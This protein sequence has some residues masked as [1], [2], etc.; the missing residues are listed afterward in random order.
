MSKTFKELLADVDAK[1]PEYREKYK[2]LAEAVQALL[3]AVDAGVLI[4]QPPA[5]TTKSAA[6]V[7]FI[8]FKVKCIRNNDRAENSLEIGKI[9]TVIGAPYPTDYLLD[10]GSPISWARDRFEIVVEEPTP[11]PKTKMVRAMETNS[12]FLTTGK[13]YEA[14][15]EEYGFDGKAYMYSLVDDTGTRNKFYITRFE[16]VLDSEGELK[17]QTVIAADLTKLT[18]DLTYN[19]DAANAELRTANNTIKLQLTTIDQLHQQIE[20]EKA[21]QR[22]MYMTIT[23]QRTLIDDLTSEKE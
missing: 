23:K 1:F 3:K 7:E 15:N 2:P 21:G 6:S 22:S 10:C 5:S 9:Y 12:G 17:R 18:I 13:I 20:S 19:L 14:L 16:D 11:A 8:P 4:V